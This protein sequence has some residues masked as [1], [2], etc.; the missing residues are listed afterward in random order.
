MTT[1]ERIDKL[2]DS[3]K[4]I[5][6]AQATTEISG[7]DWATSMMIELELLKTENIKVKQSKQKER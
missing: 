4:H 6:A 1:D 2:I 5:V 3:I 7:T